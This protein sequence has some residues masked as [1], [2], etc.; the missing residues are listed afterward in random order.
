MS[1]KEAEAKASIDV[2]YADL[3]SVA[4]TAIFWSCYNHGIEIVC[5]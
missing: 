4:I 2:T 5:L 3:I 1:R